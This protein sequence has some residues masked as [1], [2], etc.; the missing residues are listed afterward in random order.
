MSMTNFLIFGTLAIAM[1]SFFALHRPIS[2]TQILPKKVSNEAFAR[3][4]EQDA[5]TKPNWE[6]VISTLSQTVHILL[7]LCP[8]KL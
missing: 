8:S 4:F 7:F 6:D 2:V 1:A 5:P 3:I